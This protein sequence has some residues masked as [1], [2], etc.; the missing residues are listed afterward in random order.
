MRGQFDRLLNGSAGGRTGN[1]A[2]DWVIRGVVQF[3]IDGEVGGLERIVA[4]CV[5]ARGERT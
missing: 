2:F 5:T 4:K 3:G 1:D